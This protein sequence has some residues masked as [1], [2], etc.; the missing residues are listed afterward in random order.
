VGLEHLGDLRQVPLDVRPPS[1]LAQLEGQERRHRVAD[2]RR[3]D[4]R[5]L[6]A[7]Q[8]LALP[9]LQ[10]CLHGAARDPPPPGEL[11]HAGARLGVQVDEQGSVEGVERSVRHGSP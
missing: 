1:L 2:R 9:A 3:V 6:S 11:E 5:T 8:P 7:H 4:L 10:T